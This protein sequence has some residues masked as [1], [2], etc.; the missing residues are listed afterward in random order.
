MV[1]KNWKFLATAEIL[2][3]VCGGEGPADAENDFRVLRGLDDVEACA[4]E[5][6]V[7]RLARETLK[8]CVIALALAVFLV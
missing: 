5:M 2:H 4:I 7:G 8:N 6:T 1:K 3:D